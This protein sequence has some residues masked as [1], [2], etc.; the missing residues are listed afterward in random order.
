M[1]YNEMS[2]VSVE[3]EAKA[4]THLRLLADDKLNTQKQ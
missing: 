1:A 3:E 4:A 2:I